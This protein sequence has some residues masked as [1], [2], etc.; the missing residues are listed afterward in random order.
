MTTM[1]ANEILAIA[2]FLGD[3]MSDAQAERLMDGC[4]TLSMA[5]REHVLGTVGGGKL[6]TELSMHAREMGGLSRY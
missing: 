5:D 4:R 2:E 3:E 6:H 1:T